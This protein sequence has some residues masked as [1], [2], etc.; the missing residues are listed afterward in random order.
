[1]TE[2]N[3]LCLNCVHHDICKYESLYYSNLHD[4]KNP[5]RKGRE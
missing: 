4:L 3:A 5:F 2:M 1:M